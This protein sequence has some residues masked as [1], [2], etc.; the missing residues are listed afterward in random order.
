MFRIKRVCCDPPC[1][2][3][4]FS[5]IVSVHDKDEI[6][7]QLFLSV[8]LRGVYWESKTCKLNKSIHCHWLYRSLSNEVFGNESFIY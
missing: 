1:R 8:S 7:K 3:G 6:Y 2:L 5:D 4:V